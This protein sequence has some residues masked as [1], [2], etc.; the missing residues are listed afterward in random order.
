[1]ND[2]IN[3]YSTQTDFGY[4]FATFQN[5]VWNLTQ[6]LQA[7]GGK[8]VSGHKTGGFRSICTDSRS[9]EPGDLFLALSGDRHDGVEFVYDAVRKGASGV[10]V[11]RELDKSVPV[12]V[13]VVNET[14]KA[15][16]DMAAFR[17]ALMPDLRLI[18]I[19]GSSG[20]TT[21]KEMT[22][23]IL[24][25]KYNV[26]KTKG[27]FN[28]L[29]GLPL[30]LLPVDYRHDFAVM[31]MGM[32]RPGEIARLTE[33]AAPNIACI[34]NVQESHLA[35][36]NSLDGVAAAKGE[37]FQGMKNWGKLVVNL[38]DPKIVGL[39]AACT[40][41]KITFGFNRKAHVRATHIRNNGEKG[42]A[43][44]LHVG[45][46]KRRV[47]IN[48]IGI[49]NIMN[50]LAAAA[51]THAAG[52]GLERIAT[53]LE[54]FKPFNK[55]LQVLELSSGVKIVNDTYNANPSS[56]RAALD[57]LSGLNK[58]GKRTV[59]VL[60]DMLELGDTSDSAHRA[61]GEYVAA[62]KVD[63][64][65]LYGSNFQATAAGARN[66]SM[67]VDRIQVFKSKAA[68]AT[69]LERMMAE[70]RLSK[71]DWVL[72]KGSRGMKMETIID[73]LAGAEKEGTD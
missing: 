70:H 32:N 31:E 30:S 53:G 51:M 23:A 41:Q 67:D 54:L 17:R 40:Q 39:A 33:I 62:M 18:A 69:E 12:P 47:W 48:G 42:M 25:Q 59:V 14:L 65:M 44:S 66:A 55:R 45:K 36:L 57:A 37:L 58:E 35:G 1:M 56:V 64:L 15:L 2:R 4:G 9:I 27:N 26:I 3:Q 13:I 49:H 21:V 28:N 5:P 71:G 6:V 22:A 68:L 11:S 43:Y 60:G 34:V 24:S 61:I 19:T 7:T 38:D 73:T 8:V 63:Y 29:I 72:V 52:L 20:K 46:E 10:I 50:S 16:G